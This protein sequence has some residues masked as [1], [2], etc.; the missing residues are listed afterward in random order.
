MSALT[1]FIEAHPMIWETLKLLF[2]AAVTFAV[3][4]LAL[5]LEKKASKKLFGR[6]N[7]INLRFVE[8]IARFIVI[9]L[10][11]QWVVMSSSITQSFGRVLFQGTTVIAAIAG[12]AAQP[13]IA[14]MICG[15]MLSATK[16]FDIGD[17]IELEDGTSG[18]VKDISLRHVTLRDID[19]VVRIIPNSRLNGMKI[20]NMSWHTRTRSAHMRFH[21][22]YDT[23]I[24]RAMAVI[25]GAV[26]ESPYTVAGKPGAAGS[27]EYGPVYFIE[28]ADSSLVLATT[29]YYD[30]A[31]PTEAVKS[32]VNLRVMKALAANGIEI[33][34]GYVNVVM[35]RA[36]S[37]EAADE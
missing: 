33:P 20:T 35:K 25:G 30:P 23:D 11:V 9:F 3:V 27:G 12:F 14:D 34:Y 37:G 26:A 8:N 29:V 16:P 28:Y 13:V 7:T 15:L 22:A 5:R 31:T 18:I 24:E 19:T 6:R 1:D 4:Y 21:V 2:T 17:R 36:P 10:A 32:D